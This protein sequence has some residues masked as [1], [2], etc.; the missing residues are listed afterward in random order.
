[1]KKRIIIVGVIATI[2]V[3]IIS[4][5]ENIYRFYKLNQIRN[6]CIN[7]LNG[8]FNNRTSP[9]IVEEYELYH[10]SIEEL[11]HYEITKFVDAYINMTNEAVYLYILRQKGIESE[12]KEKDYDLAHM[13]LRGLEYGKDMQTDGADFTEYISYDIADEDVD[14]FNNGTFNQ[15]LIEK[16]KKCLDYKEE[17]GKIKWEINSTEDKRIEL[18]YNCYIDYTA[19]HRQDNKEFER[20]IDIEFDKNFELKKNVNMVS[21]KYETSDGRIKEE[22]EELFYV[23]RNDKA[24][25]EISMYNLIII[26]ADTIAKAMLSSHTCDRMSEEERLREYKE[27]ATSSINDFDFDTFYFE[28]LTEEE[29]ESVKR[30]VEN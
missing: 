21:V 1:M 3:A 22:K 10:K 4:N 9:I 17:N 7:N 23:I 30:A 16:L 5:H 25:Y 18:P 14:N 11:N 19:Y 15:K 29:R 8:K 20:A 12:Y 2:L 28:Q 24:Y 6:D 26:G 27:W 13:N